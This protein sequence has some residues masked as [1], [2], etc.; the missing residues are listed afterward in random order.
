MVNTKSDLPE[1]LDE[2]VNIKATIWDAQKK[3]EKYMGEVTVNFTPDSSKSVEKWF[4]LSS[5]NKT[6]VSG[7]IHLS[8]SYDGPSELHDFYFTSFLWKMFYFFAG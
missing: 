1:D 2:E 8:I 4:K 7:E 5:K 3:D 6:K